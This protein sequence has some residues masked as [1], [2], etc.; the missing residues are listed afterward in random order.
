MLA[1]FLD[2]SVL[3]RRIA[4]VFAKIIKSASGMK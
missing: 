1:H 2:V 3:L 4:V